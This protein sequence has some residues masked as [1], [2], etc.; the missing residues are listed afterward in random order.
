MKAESV[1]DPDEARELL[2]VHELF[3]KLGMAI[4]TLMPMLVEYMPAISHLLGEA[5]PAKEKHTEIR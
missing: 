1:A 3:I 2:G 4:T 5:S